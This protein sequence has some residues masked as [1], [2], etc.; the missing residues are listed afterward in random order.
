MYSFI[1]LQYNHKQ[2]CWLFVHA[3][4]NILSLV[5]FCWSAETHSSDSWTLLS[6]TTT[7]R[8]IDRSI[9]FI[10]LWFFIYRYV[11]LL[12]PWNRFEFYQVYFSINCSYQKNIIKLWIASYFP[13][14][15]FN[16][17]KRTS[18]YKLLFEWYIYKINCENVVRRKSNSRGMTSFYT[19]SIFFLRCNKIRTS[20]GC[21]NARHIFVVNWCVFFRSLAL[22]VGVI[23]CERF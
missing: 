12:N 21:E 8:A 3:H 22:S 20:F 23:C 15:I 2:S 16:Q 13:R 7:S 10:L 4:F 18:V 14:T 1:S 9:C 6:L 19:S 17:S 5:E 11:I